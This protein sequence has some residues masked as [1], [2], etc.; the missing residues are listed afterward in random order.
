MSNLNLRRFASA[1]LCRHISRAVGLERVWERKGRRFVSRTPSSPKEK[2]KSRH[3]SELFA[4]LEAIGA[5]QD[6]SFVQKII[7]YNAKFSIVKMRVSV[8]QI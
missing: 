4:L 8:H 5:I 2:E 6:P 1:K 7:I 3:K